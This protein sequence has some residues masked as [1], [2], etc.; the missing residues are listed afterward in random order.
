MEASPRQSINIAKQLPD[1][2]HL[3][4]AMFYDAM[5]NEVGLTPPENGYPQVAVNS[6][7]QVP[8]FVIQLSENQ[9][10]EN[11]Y[12]RVPK[13]TLVENIANGSIDR[14][15]I[16]EFMSRKTL[17]LPEL[18]DLAQKVNGQR[19]SNIV[20]QKIDDE[21]GRLSINDIYDLLDSGTLDP[22]S[23]DIINSAL[24]FKLHTLRNRSSDPTDSS[25]S[26][27]SRV[28]P[29]QEQLVSSS[30]LS[31]N[32]L[33]D[34]WG[35]PDLTET[36]QN[37][38]TPLP[39]IHPADEPWS[40][41]DTSD[42]N[43]IPQT[44]TPSLPDV[45]PADAEWFDDSSQDKLIGTNPTTTSQREV[46]EHLL[47]RSR[48]ARQ[49][50]EQANI[51]SVLAQ[52]DISQPENNKDPIDSNDQAGVE[53]APVTLSVGH[54]LLNILDEV[55]ATGK[56][57][58]L[59]LT[60]DLVSEVI[61]K[62]ETDENPFADLTGN[63]INLLI[64]ELIVPFLLHDYAKLISEKTGQKVNQ[65]EYGKI[66]PLIK[67]IL[68]KNKEKFPELDQTPDD[69]TIDGDFDD[70]TNEPSSTTI[71]PAKDKLVVT[72]DDDDTDDTIDGDFDDV[73]ASD[74]TTDLTPNPNDKL[75]VTL[76]EEDNLPL[77]MQFSIEEDGISDEAMLNFVNSYPKE[78][79]VRL[80][81]MSK[82]NLLTFYDMVHSE[83]Q[84][85]F[86]RLGEV[87]A[88]RVVSGAK[89][90]LRRARQAV[91]ETRQAA[92]DA[93]TATQE[94][95]NEQRSRLPKID[96]QA[97][98]ARIPPEARA[99]FSTFS[100]ELLRDAVASLERSLQDG[101]TLSRIPRSAAE[102]KGV[103]RRTTS[104]VARAAVNT[105]QRNLERR[106]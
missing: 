32:D 86:V 28:T 10:R 6:Q 79:R 50:A 88:D 5:H 104:A 18:T 13:S 34:I 98:L 48:V 7:I 105:R 47:K 26:S 46:P 12:F 21:I 23:S 9:K 35:E 49:R 30:K 78:N 72:L 64:N 22:A 76:D 58:E 75:I 38:T 83:D 54:E 73:D 24:D 43:E 33:P 39:E 2:I 66:E 45:L 19:N 37:V 67:R 44:T 42:T 40:N 31:T 96:R 80:R 11:P 29:P 62:A 77:D 63:E 53:Q 95:S 100:D 60:F 55:Y 85:T 87:A 69:D 36:P 1:D 106:R 41:P 51:A 4:P 20:L 61:V 65:I 97:L 99:S 25:V 92:L 52:S 15:L 91:E 74:A 14:D 70:D 93:R 81:E 94:P 101:T 90:A 59:G 82:E 84:P 102:V 3:D 27:E 89:S 68:S 17:R 71:L 103:A 8:E 56:K 16:D 57:W